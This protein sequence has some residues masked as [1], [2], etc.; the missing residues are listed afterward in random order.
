MKTYPPL[1]IAAWMTISLGALKSEGAVPVD[2]LKSMR[3]LSYTCRGSGVSHANGKNTTFSDQ[4]EY[5]A[6]GANFIYTYKS[7]NDAQDGGVLLP[8]RTVA[9]NSEIFQVV[10]HEEKLMQIT[11]SAG[12]DARNYR[13]VSSNNMG[14]FEPYAFL[15]AAYHG[16]MVKQNDAAH[17]KLAKPASMGFYP[18]LVDFISSAR[19]MA[20]GAYANQFW[21]R[22]KDGKGVQVFK[23]PGLS[24]QGREAAMLVRF[25][26][27]H[28]G[29]P[30]Q[31]EMVYEGDT[32]P[33]LVWK[34]EI[35]SFQEI[36]GFG[37][38]RRFEKCAYLQTGMVGKPPV[39]ISQATY[40]I[41]DCTVNE[42]IETSEFTVDPSLVDMIQDMDSNKWIRVPK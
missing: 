31:W 2:A 28:S 15:A 18:Q 32:H 33:F 26:S 3:T 9:Y 37:Y 13:Y 25:S 27:T 14:L 29:L 8:H 17:M 5:K 42:P 34:A 38:F 39:E 12:I 23:V 35:M 21:L 20:S 30:S 36:K 7:S 24:D 16:Y 1:L 4:L 11:K 40:E 19:L 6:S 41:V 22:E 10:L